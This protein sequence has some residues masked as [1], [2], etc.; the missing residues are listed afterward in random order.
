MVSL[1]HQ[2]A[3]QIGSQLDSIIRAGG[4]T[5]WALMPRSLTQESIVMAK[6]LS[7]NPEIMFRKKKKKN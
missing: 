3:V 4:E 2:W 7:C 1:I 5:L 6:R